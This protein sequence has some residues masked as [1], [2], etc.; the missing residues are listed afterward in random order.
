MVVVP[1]GGSMSL[2]QSV[3]LALI[4]FVFF[5]G[6]DLMAIISNYIKSNQ[7]FVVTQFSPIYGILI[8]IIVALIL[9]IWT[10]IMRQIYQGWTQPTPKGKAMPFQDWA[11][12]CWQIYL[13]FFLFLGLNAYTV[14]LPLYF[15]YSV[16]SL[17]LALGGAF[18]IGVYSLVTVYF[19]K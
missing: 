14:A 2:A 3:H 4:A 19:H 18:L 9:G 16:V 5:I 8:G 10:T 7:S 1:D 15:V 11:W 13:A 12:L 17:I 6:L